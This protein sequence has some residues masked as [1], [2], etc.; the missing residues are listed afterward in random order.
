MQRV[1]RNDTSREE[2]RAIAYAIGWMERRVAP[3]VG[4]ARNRPSMD[5]MGSG[6]DS[7]GGNGENPIVQSAASFLV[8]ILRAALER[9]LR[10]Y[11]S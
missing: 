1:R 9:Q 7:S 4:T 10:D 11:R 8:A 3:T 6:D 5:F 2:R